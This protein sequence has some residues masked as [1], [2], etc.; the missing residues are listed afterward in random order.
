MKIEKET[1]ISIIVVILLISAVA[2]IMIYTI[3]NSLIVKCSKYGDVPYRHESFFVGTK[4]VETTRENA[5]VFKR[6]CI[7]GELL[8][9]NK[10][11]KKIN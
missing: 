1:I 6:E 7:D 5:D 11:L 8:N 4:L 9:G 10:F 3:G 2:Y